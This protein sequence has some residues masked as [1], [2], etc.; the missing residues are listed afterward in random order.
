[1]PEPPHGPPVETQRDDAAHLAALF[2]R[3]E[4]GAM[5]IDAVG[6]IIWA[7][8]RFYDMIGRV[9]DAPIEGCWWDLLHPAER[10]EGAR[11]AAELMRSGTPSSI[12]A[13]LVGGDGTITWASIMLSAELDQTGRPGFGVGLVHD[14][15]RHKLIEEKLSKA[16]GDLAV[17]EARYRALGEA[18]DYGLWVCD[19]TGRCLHASKNLLDFLGVEPSKAQEISWPHYLHP[20][21]VERVSKAWLECT[22]RGDRWV[23]EHRL[24]ARDGE[25]R[26]VL[27]LGM[28]L[29]HEG[30]RI[31][32]WAGLSIDITMLRQTQY[33]LAQTLIEKDAML[34]QQAVLIQEINHR[35][36]N[37]LQ[38]AAGV[39]TMHG[40]AHPDPSLA[41]ALEDA[42]GRLMTI[43]NIHE[44]LCRLGNQM[45][46]HI[47][48]G[49][50]LTDLCHD[51]TRLH[52]TDAEQCVMTVEADEVVLPVG[53]ATS[54]A[55]LVNELLTNVAKYA[56]SPGR[57]TRLLVRF[58]RVEDGFILQVEDDGPGFPP[59]FA[60]ANATGLGMRIVQT[61]VLQLDGQ[62]SIIQGRPGAQITLRFPASLAGPPIVPTPR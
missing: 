44:R 5:Q 23:G 35:I 24:R 43:A 47:E 12:D 9:S 39:L 2:R 61:L 53:E 10:D 14:I 31:T 56:L 1:M 3:A 37:N 7:N 38:L 42:V 4:V 8:R 25:Y 32:E 51:L 55:L 16:L 21:E 52:A 27:A 57:V 28:P 58:R 33:Q 59:G 17:S 60:I 11:L 40:N 20:D 54:L 36:K 6:R 26:H 13:R 19:T 45:G 22:A 49:Q 41:A 15:T 62:I 50:Y 46:G 29:R 48:F 30:G 18:F 34:Q